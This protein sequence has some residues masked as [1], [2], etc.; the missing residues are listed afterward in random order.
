MKELHRSVIITSEQD[1]IWTQ[2]SREL[3]YIKIYDI[4]TGWLNDFYIRME[5]LF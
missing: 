2:K 1:R 4:S 3:Y 5:Y